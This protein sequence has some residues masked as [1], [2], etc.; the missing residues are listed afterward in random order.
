M[1]LIYSVG[2]PYKQKLRFPGEEFLPQNCS[3]D[4]R[5]REFPARWPALQMSDLPSPEWHEPIRY[6]TPVG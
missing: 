4:R 3:T 6:P 2:K 1:D 5:L